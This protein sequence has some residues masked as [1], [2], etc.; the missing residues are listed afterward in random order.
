[1]PWNNLPLD[2]DVHAEQV[3]IIDFDT[4]TVLLQK[5]STQPMHPSSMTKIMT[6]YRVIEKIKQGIIKPDTLFIVSKNGWKVEGSSMFLNIHDRVKVEDLLK[7]LII[8]S[9]ND[10]GI[11]LAE[12]IAGSEAAFARD[13]TRRAKDLGAYDTYFVN[14]S[15]LPHPEHLTTAKDLATLSMHA[16]K[17][18]PEYYHLYSEKE[19]TYGNIRQG[20]RNPLLYKN[21][22]CDGIKTGHTRIAGY[23][24]VATS[25]EDGR[26][27]IVVVNGLPS[28][29]ARA[30]EVMKLMTWGFRTFANKTLVNA[31][32]AVESRPV[33]HGKANTV[34]IGVADPVVVTFPK[35]FENDIK[36][37]IELPET[38]QTPIN[39]GDVIGKM[40]I[41]CP[42]FE[43]SISV[44]L[45][46]RETV[47]R[48]GFFRRVGQMIG[49]LFGFK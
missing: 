29:Q 43:H 1:M 46:A 38:C 23:G 41:T 48:S 31:G 21:V 11:V 37:S 39:K 30:D 26:R 2:I 6:A 20:N 34:S 33:R 17:D 4:G 45:V 25:V 5:N 14:A 13:M 3:Y 36:T 42:A 19:F 12:N 32:H 9:G 44:N 27:L 7:G 22:G 15:G 10:A 35:A 16:I 18:Q 28:A 24:M 49:T 40:I 47:E 8:Q